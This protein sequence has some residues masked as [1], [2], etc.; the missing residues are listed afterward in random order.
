MILTSFSSRSPHPLDHV[1]HRSL[2]GRGS[3]IQAP[4][5]YGQ[6]VFLPSICG[7]AT[8]TIFPADTLPGLAV[9]PRPGDL[10]DI[11]LNPSEP[12]QRLL[13]FGDLARTRP[14]RRICCSCTTLSV[15][16]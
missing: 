5:N 8:D 7:G 12:E 9:C 11:L 16:L 10:A 3:S 4:D 13:R 1:Q 15:K 14:G 2:P 6:S